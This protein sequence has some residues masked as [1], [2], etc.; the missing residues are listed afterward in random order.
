MFDLPKKRISLSLLI[1]GVFFSFPNI[2]AKLGDT[3]YCQ[4]KEGACEGHSITKI[5]K[6]RPLIY[7][8]REE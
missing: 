4:S 6:L 7:L 8:E 1:A 3:L 2:D 5:E